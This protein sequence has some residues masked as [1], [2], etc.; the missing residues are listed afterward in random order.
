M[1]LEEHFESSSTLQRNERVNRPGQHT[2]ATK[3]RA[4]FCLR[5]P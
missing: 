3:P 2:P 1:R 4:G 5:P